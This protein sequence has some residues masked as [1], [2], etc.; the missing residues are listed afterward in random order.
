M[1]TPV[2]NTMAEAV[3]ALRRRGFT[4]DFA[5]NKESQHVGA[6]DQ[7]FKSDELIIVDY[8]TPTAAKVAGSVV[9]SS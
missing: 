4:T 7:T 8:T 6:G 2:Y 5:V 1:T 3:E 9:R